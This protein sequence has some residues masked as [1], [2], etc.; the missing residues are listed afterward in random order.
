[1][2]ELS[3]EEKSEIQTN[4]TNQLQLFESQFLTTISSYGLPTENIFVSVEE[5]SKVF[6]NLK[7]VFALLEDSQKQRSIYLSKFLAA[8]ASGL[9]DAALNYLWD[10]TISEIRK[11]VIQYDLKY[12]YDTATSENKR[13]KLKGPEDIVKLDDSELIT[14]SREIGLISE[15]GFKH[16]EYIKYMRNW[17]SAAHP[18]QNQLTGLQLISWLETCIKEAIS[19]PLSNIVTEIKQLLANIR[20]SILDTN[21]ANE[22]ASFFILLSPQQ[23]SNLV[24]GFLGI[25]TDSQTTPQTRV[26]IQYLLPHLWHLLENETK[27]DIG[28]RYAKHTANNSQELQALT[29]AFLEVVDGMS[30]IPDNLKA[31]E[32]SNSIQNL[33]VA[34]RNNNNFHSEPP[35]ARE[36]S[37]VVGQTGNIPKEIRVKY[38]L[39]IVEVFL[40]NGLGV[41][42]NAEPIY[43]GLINSFSQEEA[44]IS[45]LSF[46]HEHISSRLQHTLCAEKYQ[47]LV[48]LIRNKLTAPAALEVLS[49]VEEFHGPLDRMK[50]DTRLQSKIKSMKAILK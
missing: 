21:D 33:L 50:N 29:K 23:A 14:G 6:Q 15:L 2:K 16:L 28:L 38:V 46:S 11:R 45:L 27:Y 4:Y 32:I 18:N 31:V 1:M 36:L 10:E 41:A 44:L 17:A 26:N 24:F 9:F 22:I 35:F 39:C 5:R 48:H 40:T 19:L 43:T 47:S 34:H 42:W 8:T 3:K 13:K 7:S 25:Y 49:A 37:R 30:F 12:F 20:T